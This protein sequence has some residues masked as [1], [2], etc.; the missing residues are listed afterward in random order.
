[1]CEGV[2]ELWVKFP[3]Q[4]E[5]E[6]PDTQKIL[7]DGTLI[8]R[9]LEILQMAG[10]GLDDENVGTIPDSMVKPDDYDGFATYRFTGLDINLKLDASNYKLPLTN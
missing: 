5:Y 4:A 10:I 9:I 8:F 2:P 7:G 3:E 1:M 6:Q